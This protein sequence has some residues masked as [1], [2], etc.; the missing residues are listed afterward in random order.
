MWNCN[1]GGIKNIVEDLWRNKELEKNMKKETFFI[2]NP[3]VN[4]NKVSIVSSDSTINSATNPHI[5][6]ISEIVQSFSS[7]ALKSLKTDSICNESDH[8][9][10]L[11]YEGGGKDIYDVS[12]DTDIELVCNDFDSDDKKHRQSILGNEADVTLPMTR[13]SKAVF[14]EDRGNCLLA[15]NLIDEHGYLKKDLTRQILIDILPKEFNI[16][17][18]SRFYGY[19]RNK[20]FDVI[21][22]ICRY[23][24]HAPRF[25]F[26]ISYSDNGPVTHFVYS[27]AAEEVIHDGPRHYYQ[28][29]GK[30]R[31]ESRKLMQTVKP[32]D[33][34]G[35]C[36]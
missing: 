33:S 10:F 5:A 28:L 25:K 4:N 36:T 19:R 3:D 35:N 16:T 21:Y 17:C 2:K 15:S 26:D 8:H 22:G 31:E 23:K 29:A 18:T 20:D 6:R 9:R 30:A 27:D 24:S 11:E 13:Q 12:T 14:S 32:R 7:L 1:D 34:S